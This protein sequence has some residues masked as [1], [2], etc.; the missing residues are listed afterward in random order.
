M[1]LDPELL[2]RL[3]F[4]FV[5]SFHIL[6]PAFT[7]GLA[8]YIAVLE[9]LWTLTG[10]K[11]YVELSQFWTK[12]FAVS[13]GMGVVSGIVM[14]YQF[15]TNW[16]RFSDNTAPTIGPL[17]GYEVLTAFFLE[18]TFLGVLLF[19]RER[20]PRALHL[21]SAYAVA[22]GTLV[23][24]FWILSA[25]SWMQ[26]PAG[27]DI[28]QGRFVAVDYWKVIFNPSF[29]YRFAHMVTACYLTTAFFVVGL[30]AWYLR[31]DRWTEH[32]RTAMSMGLG[33]IAI[34]APAQLIIGDMHGLNTLEHQPVK[35]AAMEGH[36]EASRAGA[37][38]VLFGVPDQAEERNHY[39][40]AIPKL[41]SLILTHDPNG[42]VHGLKAWPRK[43]RPPVPVVFYAFRVMVGIGLLMIFIGMAG[44][45]LRWRK[46]LFDTPWFLALCNWCLPLG[47]FALLAGWFVTEVGR[48]PWTVYG[49]LRTVDS[50]TPSLSGGDVLAS[51]L[52]YF[53]A[54]AAI[55]GGGAY[56]M[57][58]MA[59][60]GPVPGTLKGGVVAARRPLS[61]SEVTM[62]GDD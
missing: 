15:G 31:R 32:A 7:I 24:A 9:T 4:G 57:T 48:Q 41:G 23:S 28:Q 50:V 18:A 56:Y 14:S 45:Y 53:L 42:V 8:S 58:R 54:Y 52:V 49:Q 34:L 11:R 25:N 29:P 5:V 46:R 44:L 26:T 22:F 61:G 21:L 62:D 47:F 2:S 55:F 10:R 3:Q 35:V 37:P 16:S 13:F 6:F 40:I 43:D 33:L 38:F 17:L 12:F 1:A 19:G 51:I 60:K 36:W 39:E 20:V 30:S 59:Q 27:F